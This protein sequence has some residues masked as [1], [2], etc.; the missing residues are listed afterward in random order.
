MRLIRNQVNAF[1]I[2]ADDGTVNKHSTRR[3]ISV[4]RSIFN[5]DANSLLFSSFSLNVHDETL[6]R[7]RLRYTV[8]LNCFYCWI[9]VE[10]NQMY[11]ILAHSGLLEPIYSLICFRAVP[12][13]AHD[14]RIIGCAHM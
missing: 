1:R 4:I 11:L 12:E 6:P 2:R 3:K 8:Y 7:H 5:Q 13:D 10:F 9:R 14:I